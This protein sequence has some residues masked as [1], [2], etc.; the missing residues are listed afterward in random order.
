MITQ[1]NLKKNS[2]KKYSQDI[3]GNIGLSDY[4]SI[5]NQNLCKQVKTVLGN[6]FTFLKDTF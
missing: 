4:E 5:S 2:S 3:L 6:K 1:K